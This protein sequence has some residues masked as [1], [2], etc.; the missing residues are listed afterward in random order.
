MLQFFIKNI[1]DFNKYIAVYKDLNEVSP[2]DDWFPYEYIDAE[3]NTKL[4]ETKG[5]IAGD[6]IEK[7]TKHYVKYLIHDPNWL[8]KISIEIDNLLI[9]H[10]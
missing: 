10:E 1:I 2:P 9:N 8:K 3:V 7:Y 4:E 6:E 5:R